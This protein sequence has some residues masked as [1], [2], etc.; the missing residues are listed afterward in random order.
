METMETSCDKYR[1]EKF[2]NY[3]C[4]MIQC[5]SIRNRFFNFKQLILLVYDS[6]LRLCITKQKIYKSYLKLEYF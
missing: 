1:T 3:W 6:K 5:T 2:M 4:N